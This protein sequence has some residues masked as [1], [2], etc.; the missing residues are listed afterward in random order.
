M[1]KLYSTYPGLS[2]A[3]HAIYKFRGD[4]VPT[5]VA[6]RKQ[7]ISISTRRSRNS[8]QRQILRQSS[9]LWLGSAYTLNKKALDLQLFCSLV[10]EHSLA[11]SSY[12]DW[13][14]ATWASL[15]SDTVF[16]SIPTQ[17]MAYRIH[18]SNHSGAAHSVPLLRRNA[19]KGLCTFVIIDDILSL[20]PRECKYA[21]LIRSKRC[22]YEYLVSICDGNYLHAFRSL[23]MSLH[24]LISRPYLFLKE[25]VRA[26]FLLVFGFS[27][28][29]YFKVSCRTVRSRRYRDP[30]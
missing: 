10:K 9:C 28:Y 29:G 27:L 5:S 8:L 3:T 30:A 14:L 21:P 25:S 6:N 13:P 12:Q 19:Y 16:C 26:S 24:F 23:F 20:Y 7:S 4:F 22:Y 11:V 1:V 15:Q 18:D 2:F 17:L